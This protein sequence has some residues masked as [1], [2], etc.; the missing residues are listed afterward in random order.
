ME[1]KESVQS[2]V[3]SPAVSLGS[4]DHTGRLYND[5]EDMLRLGKKQEVPRNFKFF[6]TLGFVAVFVSSWEF[7]LVS[8]WGGLL[9][10]GFGGLIWEYLWTFCLYSTVVVS[11]AEMSSMAP[12][13]GG[14]YHWVSEFAPPWCQ[15]FLSYMAGWT[16]IVA[17][18]PAL[19][20]GLYPIIVILE[21][22]IV[23]WNED[24]AFTRWQQSLLMIAFGFLTIPFNTFWRR[25]LP[26]FEIIVLVLHFAGFFATILPLWI[27]APKNSASE[28]FTEVVNS[29]GWSNT[30]LSLLIGQ[31]TVLYCMA[32]FDSAVH[33]AEEVEDAARNV[34]RS[35]VWAFLL[36][37]CMGF[38]MLITYCF[39]IGSLDSALEADEPFV[40]TFL[41]VGSPGGA[42]GLT[43]ILFVLLICGNNTCTTTESRQL[44][45]FSR[46][47]GLPGSA[48]LSKIHPT[49]GVPV[50]CIMVTI[51][52]NI[53]LCLINLGSDVAFNIII[54]IQMV[55]FLATYIISIGCLLGKRLRGEPLP[56]ARWS[57]GRW[58][59]PI[60]AIALC[61]SCFF[62]IFCFFPLETPVTADN[63]NYAIAIFAVVIAVSLGFWFVQGRKT[64]TAPV[65]FTAGHRT[66]DMPLQ[67]I[68]MLRKR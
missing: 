53:V 21:T 33:L 32:G 16:S 7:V 4:Q 61:Y 15:K 60:N 26:M 40:N 37:G 19:A 11:L 56:P 47:H 34:P 57:L 9:N 14:Q 24:F 42:T 46:D 43:L 55:G 50:N 45:A 1:L 25:F 8:T 12:T 3:D 17:W 28:V 65:V 35:M 41:N 51:A 20:G 13:A 23:Y 38:V 30:G 44:W 62:I 52:I 6:A 36:N 67:S 64:Y 5:Q 27:L 59:L 63:M 54:S 39:C 2:S 22:M 49:W 31:V 10:G 29:G 18:Q 58:G 48:W 66:G 68:A